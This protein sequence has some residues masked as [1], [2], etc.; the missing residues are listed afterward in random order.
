M[1]AEEIAMDVAFLVG[2]LPDQKLI[3]AHKYILITRSS[4]F[5]AMFQGGMRE[6]HSGKP[7]EVPDGTPGAFGALLK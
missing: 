1:L 6:T 7:I 5:Y 4:V 2:E 3:R